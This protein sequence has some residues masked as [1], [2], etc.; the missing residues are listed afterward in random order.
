[1]V[2]IPNNLD[3]LYQ[4]ECDN[5]TATVAIEATIGE[6]TGA[7]KLLK[8]KL[9]DNGYQPVMIGSHCVGVRCDECV[10]E[11]TGQFDAD[12]NSEGEEEEDNVE[13]FPTKTEQTS[14]Q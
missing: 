3:I 8:E 13:A 4:V 2:R 7:V 1:M 10:K 6:H 9:T 12:D 5:C 11:T 14:G